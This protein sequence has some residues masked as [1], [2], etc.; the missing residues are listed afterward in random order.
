MLGGKFDWMTIMTILTEIKSDVGIILNTC[1]FLALWK[2]IIS[3]SNPFK[4]IFRFFKLLIL[5]VPA[6]V[7]ADWRFLH[8]LFTWNAYELGLGSGKVI[9]IIFEWNIE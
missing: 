6:L 1:H 3:M 2:S 8:G 7:K 9:S 4:V 5:K